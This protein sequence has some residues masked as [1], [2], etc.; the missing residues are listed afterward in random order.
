MGVERVTRPDSLAQLAYGQLRNG[1]LDGSFTAG[2]R[3][4]I[5]SL[6]DEMGMSRSPVR[7][8]V[9]RLATEGLLRLTEGGAEVPTPGRGDL[10]DALSVRASL[11]GLAARLAAPQL[12]A[13]DVEVLQQLHDQFVEAVETSDTRTAQRVDLEF[14]Q[15]IQARCGNDCL[16]EHL[17]LV[18]ARV[19]LATY[20]TAWSSNQRQAVPEHARILASLA[21]HDGEAAGRAATVHLENLSERIRREWSRRDDAQLPA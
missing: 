4:K 1:I 14:H 8:A 2:Q 5:V 18:Q 7:S 3:L 12:H 17:E 9:E 19:I 10:L 15:Q 16:G 20:S 6:A 11:E 21:D 13:Q